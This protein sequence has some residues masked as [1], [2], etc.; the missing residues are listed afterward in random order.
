MLSVRNLTK[1]YGQHKGLSQLSFSLASGDILGILGPNGSGKTTLFR[2]LLGLIQPTEG[3]IQIPFNKNQSLFFGYLPEERSVYK[4]ITV[5]EQITYLGRL[6]NMKPKII[7]RE[8]NYWFYRFDMLK[9][10]KHLIRELSKGNQQKVQFMCALLHKPQVLILDEPLTGLDAANVTLFKQIL[11]EQSKMGRAI[12]LSSHQYEEIET[13]CNQVILL[14]KGETALKG[15]LKQLKQAD[16]RVLVTL[17]EDHQMQYRHLDGLLEIQKEGNYT[18]Y[19]FEDR[20]SA[21]MLVNQASNPTCKI[22]PI[23]LRKL[24]EE[25]L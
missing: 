4:D 17:D 2:L 1:Y 16:G 21:E 9:Y 7:E 11:L 3:E 13:F 8:L 24:V 20:Y 5:K 19:L 12:L 15:N 6:K 22:E 25:Q 14:N 23:G 18:S 10:Q